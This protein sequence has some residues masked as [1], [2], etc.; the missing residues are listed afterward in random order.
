MTERLM[1]YRLKFDNPGNQELTGTYVSLSFTSNGPCAV[2][3]TYEFRAAVYPRD[4]ARHG[5][6]KTPSIEWYAT[7]RYTHARIVA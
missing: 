5:A 2:V 7:Q 4:A 3:V 1:K 6:L